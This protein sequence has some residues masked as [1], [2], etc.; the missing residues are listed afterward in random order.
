MRKNFAKIKSIVNQ[1]EIARRLKIDKSY[2]G[3]LFSGKRQ[4]EKRINQIRNILL[5]ELKVLKRR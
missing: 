2:V 1:A 5:K 3:L 4:N